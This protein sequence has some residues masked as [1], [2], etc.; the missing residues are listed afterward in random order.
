MSSQ[1][2]V[3]PKLCVDCRHYSPWPDASPPHDHACSSPNR[4]TISLVTGKSLLRNDHPYYSTCEEQRRTVG[5][6]AGD[7]PRC[8]HRG[9][10]F[11]PK[12]SEAE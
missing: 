6:I 12:Q 9:D 3:K 4:F 11:E 8:T 7:P 5:Y 1:P 2:I 10:W